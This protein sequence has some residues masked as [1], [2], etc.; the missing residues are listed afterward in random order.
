MPTT[1]VTA[2]AIPLDVSSK[3][4]SDFNTFG[5]VMGASPADHIGF[6]GVATPVVQ[7]VG[8]GGTAGSYT[9]TTTAIV[10]ALKQLGWIAT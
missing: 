8:D 10:T 6:F 4:L 2:Q 1:P 7:P 5:T 3:Q 9:Y